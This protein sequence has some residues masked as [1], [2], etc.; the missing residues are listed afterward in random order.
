MEKNPVKNSVEE[1]CL[2]S[3]REFFDLTVDSFA[4]GPAFV[5]RGQTAYD[6]PLESSIDRLESKYPKRKNLCGSIPEFFER[7]PFTEE[8]HLNAFKRAIRGRRG[9]NPGALSEDDYWALGQHHGLA[10][11]LLDW[12]RSPFVALF[13]AFEEEECLHADGKWGEPEYRGVYVLSTNT[14]EDAAK[15]D[16][17]AV[18]ILSPESD[19]NYRLISQAALF[20]RMPRKT[21]LEDYVAKH[22]PKENRN[23]T[24]KKIKIPND[25][26]D[27]CLVTLNKMNINHMTLFPD[28][29]GAAKHVNTRW[30]P[31]HEDSIAYV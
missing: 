31:G 5:F 18:R 15:D 1:I 14:I 24:F 8:Q 7:P 11:P 10:T 12:T 13:F 9:P 4:T 23:A 3:W 20:I 26:R 21:K 25:D 16:T 6:W 28:I 22:F 17:F 27:D 19:A 2:D 29:D 30:R